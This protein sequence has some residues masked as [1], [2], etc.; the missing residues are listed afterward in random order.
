MKTKEEFL[1]ELNRRASQEV[2]EFMPTDEYVKAAVR[3]MFEMAAE[4]LAD[5]SKPK[6]PADPV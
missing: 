1:A 4:V 2:R 3:V 5:V 6:P